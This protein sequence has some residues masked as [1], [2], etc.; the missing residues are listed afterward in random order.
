LSPSEGSRKSDAAHTG[1]QNEK[2]RTTVARH[3]TGPPRL[4]QSS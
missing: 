1:Y 3:R 2:P 4:A